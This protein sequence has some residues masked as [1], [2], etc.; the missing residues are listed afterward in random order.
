M[1]ESFVYLWIDLVGFNNMR[2]Y[3][4]SHK[5]TPDDGYVCSS[6]LMKEQFQ[7]RQ[8][9]FRRIILAEGSFEDI[10]KL[11]ADILR[12]L[13]VRENLKFY[14]Q[15]NGDGNFYNKGHSEETKRKIGQSQPTV[16]PRINELSPET[17]KNIGKWNK[18][19]VRT[20]E[21]KKKLRTAN[22]GKK[23]S[24]ETKRKISISNK[25]KNAGRT[26]SS[27]TIEKM[28]QAKLGKKRTKVC[29]PTPLSV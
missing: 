5:G 10:R 25:G 12:S 9:D 28:R 17:L 11:E 24:E 8:S 29:Q 26:F 1:M 18:G 22:L 16:K 19:R 6:K 15:H 7:N 21:H 14:N 23:Q 3:V 2:F 13:N 4:G 27:E 20:E